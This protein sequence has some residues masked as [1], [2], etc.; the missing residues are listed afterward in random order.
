MG[1]QY[2]LGVVPHAGRTYQAVRTLAA[3]DHKLIMN[4]NPQAAAPLLAWELDIEDTWRHTLQRELASFRKIGTF[5][6]GWRQKRDLF[7]LW[8]EEAMASGMLCAVDEELADLSSLWRL[9]RT[10]RTFRLLRLCR[11]K[12]TCRGSSIEIWARRD[13][14]ARKS[15][16]AVDRGGGRSRVEPSTLREGLVLRDA[17]SAEPKTLTLHCCRKGLEEQVDGV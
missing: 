16:G 10:L 14:S 13:V 4:A 12:T 6:G 1:L 9:L 15:D 5:D 17:L 11:G 7:G 8:R 2:L 3:R